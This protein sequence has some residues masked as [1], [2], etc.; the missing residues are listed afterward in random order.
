MWLYLGITSALFLGI[1]DIFKKWSLRGNHVLTVLFLS[2]C[3]A[4]TLTAPV[5]ILSFVAP[6]YLAQ[7]GLSVES[8]DLHSHLLIICKTLLVSASWIAAFFALKHLP[9]S[10]VSPIRA[11]APVWTLLG[12]TLL[13]GERLAPLHWLA[14]VIVFG[15]YYAFAL[16]GRKEGIH[17]TKNKWVL[18]ILVATLTG[19]ASGLF[20]KYLLHN[21]GLP[22]VTMQIWFSFYLVLVNGCILLTTVLRSNLPMQFAWRPSIPLIGICLIIADYLYFRALAN[23]DALIAI[24]SIVRRSSVVVSFVLGGLIFREQNKRKKFI[25]L[26]GILAGIGLLI[27]ETAR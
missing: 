20:D 27:F 15:C 18:L 3:F 7:W 11:S 25:P 4:L 9:I 14:V 12:A 16:L 17:F 22:P 10:I 13:F 21:A 2:N 23:Q 1:Y 26:L 8:L 24:L 19:A 6:G 5:F